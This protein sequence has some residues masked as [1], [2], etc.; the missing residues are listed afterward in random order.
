M[1]VANNAAIGKKTASVTLQIEFLV[2]WLDKLIFK[3]SVMSNNCLY[4]I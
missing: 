2:S 3:F 4:E 1:G